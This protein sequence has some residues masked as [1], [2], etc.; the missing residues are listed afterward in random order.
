M[1]GGG[2]TAAMVLSALSIADGVP[3]LDARV[4]AAL[5]R[6]VAVAVSGG[7]DSMAL[8]RLLAD[9]PDGPVLH[10]L[11]VDH[12]LRPAAADEARQ[13]GAW[14]ADW[15]RVTHHVLTRDKVTPG[16]VMERARADRYALMAAWCRDHGIT[17]LLTAHHRDDQAETVLFRLAKGSGL[18]G[19]AGMA[20]LSRYDDALTLCRPLL[21]VTKEELLAFCALRATPYLND[22]TNKNL[23]FARNRIR[24][25]LEEEGL[26]APRVAITAQRLRHAREALAHYAQRSYESARCGGGEGEVVFDEAVLMAEPFE[27]R[28]R[29]LLLAIEKLMP[30]RTYAPRMDRFEDIC[31]ALFD[32]PSFTRATIAGVIIA[33]R[34]RAGHIAVTRE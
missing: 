20:A 22:P 26:T 25:A 2:Y 16:R 23:N 34:R 1:H 29:V 21:G 12:G 8:L 4:R 33:R 27:T 6:A 14:V 17:H 9:I 30:D 32:D 11:T 24:Q 31:A 18:D 13:V 10:A 19:L 5:P 28:R 15:P 3:A 7:P